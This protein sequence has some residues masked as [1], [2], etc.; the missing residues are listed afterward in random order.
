MMN[1]I[2]RDWL[3][4]DGDVVLD[5]GRNPII[6]TDAV[7]IAQDIKHAILE[8]GL[9]VELVAERSTTE[10]SDLEYRIIMLAEMDLRIIPG[11]CT[12]APLNNG[13]LLTASTYEFGDVTTWL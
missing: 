5:A 6:I 7:C 8:S 10:I 1:S 3:I 13:R 4:E 9:A 12:I 2:Y 11:T